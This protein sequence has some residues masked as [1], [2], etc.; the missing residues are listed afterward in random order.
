MIEVF[1][2]QDGLYVRTGYNLPAI[3]RIKCIPGRTYTGKE[4]KLWK[5]PHSQ[6][7]RLTAEFPDAWLDESV[8]KFRQKEVTRAQVK[9]WDDAPQPADVV[10][11]LRPFQ[12]AGVAWLRTID[13]A[14]LKDDPGLGKSCQSIAWANTS[15]PC[16]IICPATMKWKYAEEIEETVGPSK[17]SVIDGR[18]GEFAEPGTDWVVI[19]WDIIGHPRKRETVEDAAQMKGRLKQIKEFGFRSVI[20]SEA[21]MAK[22]AEKSL[23]GQAAIEIA[24]SIPRRLCET[25]TPSPNRTEE[26]STI[27]RLLGKLRKEELWGWKMRFCDGH[28]I[29]VNRRGKKVWDFSGS[30]NVEELAR[31]IEPF[32]L[33][34]KKPDVLKDLPPV[35][36][37]PI[38]VDITN[39]D[40]YERHA[41]EV[42]QYLVQAARQ[43]S[44]NSKEAEK[45]AQRLRGKALGSAAALCM[46]AAMGKLDAATDLIRPYL[47][48]RRKVIVF[49]EYIEP[50]REMRKRLGESSLLMTGEITNSQERAEV[51]ERFQ[52]DPSILVALCGRRSFGMSV[53]LTAADTEVFL[54]LPPTPNDYIQARDRFNRIGQTAQ[55]LQAFW[56]VGRRTHDAAV[57]NLNWPKADIMAALY[58]DKEMQFYSEKFRDVMN[59]M[60][61]GR[62]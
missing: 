48:A 22:G 24:E 37:S 40:E 10:R 30:S 21:H 53:T 51:V 12:R 38:V 11:T 28:Q 18:S 15:L 46:T 44:I 58:R 31:F 3:A 50:L 7:D 25:A 27:L 52:K 14:L 8:S 41:A 4:T 43:D 1:A 35:S 59:L 29:V 36:E 42:Q 2:K 9:G 16:L 39:R 54:T 34:R 45:E 60:A 55:R 20:F 17:V 62:S 47:L 61:Q 6:F 56:L 57:L 49:C 26:L 32:T 33:G 19:N 23:R 13:C 5:I